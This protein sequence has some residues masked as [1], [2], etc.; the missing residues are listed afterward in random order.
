MRRYA[1]RFQNNIKHLE[2]TLYFVL[3]TKRW[4]I[5]DWI[6]LGMKGSL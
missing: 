5:K 3:T 4:E 1:Y 2:I 6:Y